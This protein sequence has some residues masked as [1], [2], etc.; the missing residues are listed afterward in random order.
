MLK[1]KL[2]LKKLILVKNKY[3]N[4][5]YFISTEFN[6]IKKRVNNSIVSN[7]DFNKAIKDLNNQGFYLVEK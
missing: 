2:N 6:E 3:I 4:F 5:K 1:L 7:I